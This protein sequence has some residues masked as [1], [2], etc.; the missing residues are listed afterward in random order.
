MAIAVALMS[1]L[2]EVSQLIAAQRSWA[3]TLALFLRQLRQPWQDPH[4]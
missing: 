1:S 3:A 2:A 4:R